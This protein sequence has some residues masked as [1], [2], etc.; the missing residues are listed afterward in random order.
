ML[1]LALGFLSR[2]RGEA[3][4]EGLALEDVLDTAIAS[5]TNAWQLDLLHA[6]D[7]IVGVNKVIS[8]KKSFE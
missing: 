3:D 2:R 1:L 4:R 7:Y 5:I 6:S 8:M